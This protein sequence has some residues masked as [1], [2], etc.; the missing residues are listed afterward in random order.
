MKKRSLLYFLIGS[1]VLINACQKE[2]SFE[3]GGSP[4]EGTLQDDG[5]GD[6]LP[7]TVAGVYVVGTALAAAT[8]YIEVQVNVTTA[9]SYTIFTDTV[10]GIYF[11]GTGVFTATGPV[12]VRLTG[13]GTPSAAGIHNFVV[14]YGTSGCSIAVTT[15]GSL[16]AFTF[17]G[18]PGGC[19]GA[20]PAGT[21]T[22]GTALTAAN[23]VN[24]NVNV[25]ALGAYSIN[26]AAA[27]G[28]TFSSSG[29]FTTLGPQAIVLTGS[30]TPTTAGATNIPITAGSSSCS[31]TVTVQAPA[32]AATFTVNCASAVVTGTYTVGTVLGAINSVGI[33][34]NVAA[35]GSYTIT[36]TVNGMTFTASG[37][38]AATG[39]Q[40]ITLFG[41]G[42]PTTAGANTVAITAG[43]APCNFTVNVN[44]AAAA[45]TFTVNCASAVVNG[46]YTI[47]TALIAANTITLPVNVTAVG[48]YTITAT[49]NGMTF[50]ATGTFA[51]ATPQNVTLA[52]T[53]TPTTAGANVVPVTGG[54]AGCNITVNVNAAAGAATFTVNCATATV[55]GTYTVGTAL[56]AANTITL[57]V[58]VTAVGTYT[59]TA[60]LN[61]M[62]F[63]ATGT[64]ATATP[65][66]VTLAGIGTPT[67]AGAN[68][69]PVTGGTAGCNITVN[70]NPA[71][72]GAATFTVDCSSAS[73]NG[74]L[75]ENVPVAAVNTITI[76]VNVTVAGTY[77]IATTP[78]NGIT[79]TATGTF[80]ATGVQTVTMNGTGTPVA[81][82]TFTLQINSGTTPC[83]FTVLVDP[84][85]GT[86]TF[87]VGATTYS[88]TIYD[89]GFDNTVFTPPAILFYIAGDNAAGD[90]FTIQMGDVNGTV[91]SAEVYNGA[92]PITGNICGV[93]FEGI[94]GT[95]YE[96]DPIQAGLATNTMVVTVTSHNA[97]T[98]TMTGTFSGK[99]LLNGGATLVDITNGA[100]TVTYP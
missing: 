72:G 25:T 23:T 7:K 67:T 49:L 56:I 26:T 57:P 69:V 58:N 96:G 100:F 11:R 20:I 28:M 87:R 80:A 60:T 94:T 66:N 51:T 42:T 31:F 50:S 29:T 75:T 16:G 48:T 19:T 52:G 82:G 33:G 8:N 63:S 24:I 54:T 40:T 36:S 81:D 65:Q 64:F 44:P 86:W 93:Y 35:T 84:N 73:L 13:Y 22:T 1:L 79:Y 21:Y 92:P 12:T 95:T 98:K 15:S 74:Y 18:A 43:T 53:G 41:S 45:A 9:G 85:Y 27:N 2:K 55:N 77:T 6:C 68:V 71:A 83:S 90:L 5:T 91:V 3:G 70:V 97:A 14:S 99:A 47:G 4:S 89:A 30:G 38:F 88:G 34:V 37:T 39:A 78:I 17:D 10:N 62:T 76:D 32:G 46:T 61:G 59:I